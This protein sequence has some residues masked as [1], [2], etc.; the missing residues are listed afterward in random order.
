[1]RVFFEEARAGQ[2]SHAPTDA[3][4][5][6]GAAGAGMAELAKLAE[7]FAFREIA[8][9]A[10]VEEQ[11]VGIVLAVNH[12]KAARGE[13]AGDDLGIE[14][15]HLTAVGAQMDTDACRRRRRGSNS[16]AGGLIVHTR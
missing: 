2:F 12:D 3:E 15:V 8:D 1:M 9:T 13:E 7:D 4:H 14:H 11:R 10:G 6:L 5:E 16:V